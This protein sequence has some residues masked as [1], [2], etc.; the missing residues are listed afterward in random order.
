[1]EKTNDG[2]PTL[3]LVHGAWHQSS[4]WVPLQEALAAD[5]W[6]SRTVELPSSGEQGIRTAGVNEDAAAIGDQ[7]RTI[8]GPVAV[9]AHS[10]GGIPVTQE[11][12]GHANVVHLVYLA[13][14]MPAEGESMYDIHRLP[15][16]EDQSGIF[17][18]IDD[19][20]T[21][22]Y[23][24]LTDAAAETALAELVDQSLR[25]F[26]QPVSRASW[27]TIPSTYIVCEKDR[28]IPPA[29]QEAMSAHA[30]HVERLAT[31]HS[32][33]LSAP[34]E[35]STRLGKILMTESSRG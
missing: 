12:A 29:L 9:L 24:D 23:G 27:R 11:A 7:L 30:S 18:L 35:L 19:P 25:S 32:P 8:D 3:L 10:Y 6:D 17:P 26:A 2:R 20:R 28:A 16:P 21:S 13:A 14:Y 34:A 31:G 15:T 4:C 33:Y 5:G 22:L 1:M